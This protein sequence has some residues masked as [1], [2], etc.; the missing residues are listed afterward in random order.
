MATL[1]VASVVGLR[2]FSRDGM[3]SFERSLRLSRSMLHDGSILTPS[4]KHIFHRYR[5]IQNN[6]KIG[7]IKVL[8]STYRSECGR[9]VDFK[10]LFSTSNA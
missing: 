5:K 4:P 10:N 7:D 2:W 9:F 8:Q 6:F 1:E 3:V